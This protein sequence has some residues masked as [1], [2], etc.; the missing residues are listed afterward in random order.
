MEQHARRLRMF[1]ERG[2]RLPVL[3]LCRGRASDARKIGLQSA[4][5]RLSDFRPECRG[6][7]VCAERKKEI[8][9]A[10]DHGGQHRLHDLTIQFEDGSAVHIKLAE[11]TASVMV[12]DAQNKMEYAD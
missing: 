10:L 4:Q 8:V 6:V 11:P 9:S 3:S 5:V 2:Y 1:R 7:L 12:R